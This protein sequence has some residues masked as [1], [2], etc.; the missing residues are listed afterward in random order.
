MKPTRSTQTRRRSSER[1]GVGGEPPSVL[2]SAV[3]LLCPRAASAAAR[4]GR[5]RRARARSIALTCAP[6]RPPPPPPPPSASTHSLFSLRKLTDGHA[7][8]PS[9]PS[10]ALAAVSALSA[11]A[12]G[13]FV[14]AR[15]Y[16]V[17]IFPR[18]FLIINI[19]LSCDTSSRKNHSD[20]YY[21]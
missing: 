20:T 21:L 9:T 5:R 15:I 17:D 7:D 13:D 18:A 11:V 14:F 16:Y 1:K 6:R 8:V 19:A 10:V 12:V 4:G 2:G 3:P